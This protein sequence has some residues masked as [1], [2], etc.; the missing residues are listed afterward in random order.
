MAEP[1]E[2][3]GAPTHLA[4]LAS[5][6]SFHRVVGTARLIKNAHREGCLWVSQ[7]HQYYFTA[8]TDRMIEFQLLFSSYR[9]NLGTNVV[10]AFLQSFPGKKGSAI[11]SR[12]TRV[13]LGIRHTA[14]ICVPSSTQPAK[15]IHIIPVSQTQCSIR[16]QTSVI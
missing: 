12:T 5:Y 2:S 10:H 9:A 13:G 4:R 3:S 8:K 11:A 1:K 14:R 15:C 6:G 16:Q 7:L